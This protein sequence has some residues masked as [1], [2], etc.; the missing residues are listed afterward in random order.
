MADPMRLREILCLGLLF[1]LVR[2]CSFAQC[3]HAT[4][5]PAFSIAPNVLTM[6][7]TTKR[8]SEDR[9]I[10]LRLEMTDNGSVRSVQVLGDY[11]VKLRA[12]AISEAVKFASTTKYID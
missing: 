10:D 8:D 6:T 4:Q 9:K 11:P 5:Q 12:A 1:V 2:Q 3:G 7:R